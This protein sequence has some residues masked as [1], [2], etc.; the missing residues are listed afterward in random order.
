MTTAWITGASSGI[1]EALARRLAATGRPVV[2]S[3][4]SAVALDALAA[5]AAGRIRSH[6]LDVTDAEAC[7]QAVAAI[8][9]E[10]GPIGLAVLNAGTH[11]PMSAD[12]FSVATARRLVEVN[13][14][15]VVNCLA[16]L[17]E[18]MRAR[19][20]GHIAI[21]ASVAGY[22]G[23]PTAAAYGATKAALINMAQS[24]KL[25]CDRL[26]I[27][28]QL[29]NPGFVKT[30]LTDRNEF[31]MPFLMPVEDA[32]TAL[33]AGLAGNRFEI[34]FPRRFALLLRLLNAMPEAAYFAAVRRF[35]GR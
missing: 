5:A 21:V 15:G 19:R 4:R 8:E 11:A 9:A 3:A 27:K 34:A 23:L 2:A 32:V 24:L 10:A 31:P 35:T 26:G 13:L 14:M 25:D 16:P 18:R 29:V 17:L 6:A 22:G 7:A 20:S 12:D 28:L 1:G 33:V 30:P